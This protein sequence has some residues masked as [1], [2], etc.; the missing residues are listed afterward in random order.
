[1]PEVN[2]EIACHAPL[3]GMYAVLL[4][5]GPWDGKEVGIRNPDAPYIQVYGPRHGQHT[6]WITHLYQRREGLY[7]FV[8]TEVVPLSASRTSRG[9]NSSL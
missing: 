4:K 3:A 6:V 2:A 7:E 9:S 5:G 1:M 8:R